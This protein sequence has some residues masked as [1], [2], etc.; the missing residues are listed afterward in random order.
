MSELPPSKIKH[1]IETA[2]ACKEIPY[3]YGEP[4]IGKSDIFF[5][6]ADEQNAEIID[7]R[8]SQMLP[9]DLTGLPMIDKSTEF[10]R[11]Y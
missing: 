7:I 9:E 11:K 10:T 6:I 8:L 2:I 3:V 4:G 5:Q 1:F